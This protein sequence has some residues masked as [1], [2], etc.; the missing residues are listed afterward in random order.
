MH[1]CLATPAPGLGMSHMD[2]PQPAINSTEELYPKNPCSF[3][4]C[5]F[6]PLLLLLAFVAGPGDLFV[7]PLA[8]PAFP[9]RLPSAISRP[10]DCRAGSSL[11]LFLRRC[12]CSFVLLLAVVIGKVTYLFTHTPHLFIFLVFTNHKITRHRNT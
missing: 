10:K 11:Y 9:P 1:S 7:H 8:P 6:V 5:C 3:L 12:F 2:N 4:R